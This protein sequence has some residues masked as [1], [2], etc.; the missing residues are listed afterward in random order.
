KSIAAERLW[1]SHHCLPAGYGL[2]RAPSSLGRWHYQGSGTAPRGPP[3]AEIGFDTASRKL[4]LGRKSPYQKF[5]CSACIKSLEA[6]EKKW[7]ARTDL[8][9]GPPACEP[10]RVR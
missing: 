2:E 7:W 9:R 3:G 8:N 1:V 6:I 10:R 5:D 4:A